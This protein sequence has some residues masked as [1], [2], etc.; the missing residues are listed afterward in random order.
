MDIDTVNW[1][2]VGGVLSVQGHQQKNCVSPTNNVRFCSIKSV[3]N[4]SS[5]SQLPCVP[6][7]PNVPCV[8]GNPPVGV[9]LPEFW[10]VWAQQGADEKV[11]QILK[12]GYTLPFKRRPV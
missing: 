12:E 3:E 5:A 11:V 4:V 1:D 6:C 10:S 8:A 2:V 7:V 9:R